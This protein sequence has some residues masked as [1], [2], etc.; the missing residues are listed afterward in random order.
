MFNI[1]IGIDP[2]RPGG[3]RSDRVLSYTDGQL[4]AIYFP[5][6]K[7]G[8]SLLQLPA[9]LMP[10]K[11]SSSGPDQVAYIGRLTDCKQ[12]GDGS[13]TFKLA[14]DPLPPIPITT[15]WDLRKELGIQDFEF[16]HTHWAIKEADLFSVLYQ[17]ALS[18]TP[19]PRI[20]GVD[21]YVPIDPDQISVMTRFRA[22]FDQVFDAVKAAAD[23][24]D[25]KCHRVRDI[26]EREAVIADIGNLIMRSRVV[27]AD[28]TDRNANVFYEYGLAHG[29]GREVIP[30][31][32]DQADTFDV[33]HLRHI[34]YQNTEA[35]R[36]DLTKKLLAR[37][38][39]IRSE[40]P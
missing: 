21:R 16:H 30:I 7:L 22:D 3:F 28:L 10:E 1:L 23:S 31:T 20:H 39:A 26:W 35:G 18:D 40:I 5:S 27:V 29:V 19:R 11:E 6:G 25:F 15:L 12:E 33:Q 34:M 4:R 32:Q 36:A 17:H 13:V 38:K 24:E 14:H 8:P 9:I 37:F 2:H